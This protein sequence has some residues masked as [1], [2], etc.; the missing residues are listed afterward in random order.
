MRTEAASRSIFRNHCARVSSQYDPRDSDSY[1]ASP[2]K[3]AI[4]R[5]LSNDQQLVFES[6]A[7]NQQSKQ[8]KK[9]GTPYVVL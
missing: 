5:A 8:E 4:G 6:L 2:L 1:Q 7:K 3:K 9:S